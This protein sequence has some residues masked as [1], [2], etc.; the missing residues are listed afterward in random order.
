MA[1]AVLNDAGTH[2]IYCVGGSQLVT[3]TVTGRVFRYDPVND[4]LTHGCGS[5]ATWRQHSAWRFRGSFE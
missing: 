2:Y 1:C 4:T 3:N 5:L